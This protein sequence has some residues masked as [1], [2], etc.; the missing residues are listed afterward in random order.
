MVDMLSLADLCK[1]LSIS[2][3]TGRNWVKLGKLVPTT[4]IKRT[5][6]F[7]QKYVSQLKKDLQNGKIPALKSRRNKKYISGNSIYRSYVS[8]TSENTASVQSIIDM[9][10]DNEIEITEELTLA[11]L[12]ECALQL[13]LDRTEK[14]SETA[15]LKGFISG[16][17]QDNPYLF[18]VS[19]LLEQNTFTAETI[20]KCGDLLTTRFIYEHN[21]D[22][23]GLLYLSLKNIGNSKAT[24]SY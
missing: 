14:V 7:T 24:G 16:R 10:E 15:S 5:P 19:D 13:I 1:E 17:Y 20:E 23:L 4:T 12:A 3:A 8:E 6:C 18:L 2:I 21:E 9:I 11:L 22:I